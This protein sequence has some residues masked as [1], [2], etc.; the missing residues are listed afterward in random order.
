MPED[1][2]SAGRAGSGRGLEA[3]IASLRPP[4]PRA[5]KYHADGW[6]RTE[7]FVDDLRAVASSDPG[8][9][10]FVNWRRDLGREVVVSYGELAE[11]VGRLSAGLRGL[12]LARGDAVAFQFPNWWEA[13][14]LL[15][16]CMD[17]GLVA[18]PVLMT[19]GGREV[20]R[21]LT[22]TGAKACV[23]VD[24]W[25]GTRPDRLLADLD[26]RLPQLRHRI[27]F[28]DAAATGAVAFADLV[29]SSP[30]PGPARGRPDEVS[31]VL[32]TSGTTGE[33]KGVLH[34]PNTLH[35]SF[36]WKGSD[37]RAEDRP[38]AM[39][40]LIHGA[41]LQTNLL[42]P[43][44]TGR[45]SVFA[46]TFDADVWLGLL[47]RHRVTYLLGSPPP[48]FTLVQAQR[49][50]RRDLPR[51]RTI[52][53]TGTSLP[54]AFV[55]PIRE[56]LCAGLTNTFGMTEIGGFSAT[57]PD[58]P[59]ELTVHSIGRP[60]P[61]REARL[62]PD[63]G[64]LEVGGVFRLH[65]RGPSVCLGTFRLDGGGVA[66]DPA[67]TDG[68]YDTGDL[69]REDG[70]GGLRYLSRVADRIGSPLTIPV[71]EVED[72]LLR[73]PSVADAAIVGSPDP[74]DGTETVCAFVVPDGAAPTLDGLRRYLLATGM[75]E[76]YLPTRLECVDALPRNHMGKV[77]KNLL[78]DR[79]R[80]QGRP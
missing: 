23:V 73:H 15:L 33:M 19:M 20:E 21:V 65:V 5:A 79:L 6:W 76:W 54:A 41:G 71:L 63:D 14:A 27:V 3:V 52:A 28:G 30:S 60:L 1:R 37:R 40:H 2:E 48:L 61:G 43:I 26:E 16:A 55:G 70:R 17:A 38:A 10:V 34:T 22:G 9:T 49:R 75:T 67:D 35:A 51:L 68:W 18:V 69:V 53:S 29:A 77:L 47:A 31:V 36:R 32:F 80:E 4:T 46:D 58:D 74:R 42:R 59:P 66:W 8:R 57:D 50:E 78:R 72:E 56:E 44:A 24:S 45:S 25:E 11:H 12:G 13:A 64:A 62:V 7:T 39:A